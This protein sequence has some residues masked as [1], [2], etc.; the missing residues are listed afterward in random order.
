MSVLGTEAGDPWGW[1]GILGWLISSASL[2]S[3]SPWKHMR[4]FPESLSRTGRPIL[5]M[6]STNSMAWGPCLNKE[7]TSWVS[8]FLSP[9][10]SSVDKLW[11][12]AACPCCLDRRCL[13]TVSQKKSL[14]P[15]VTLVRYLVTAVRKV[16]QPG[17][18][19]GT[20]LSSQYLEGRGKWVWA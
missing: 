10:L 1:L 2:G 19:G 3:G 20:D 8:T 9:H 14:L 17:G 15:E 16:T 11:P 18:G 5:N 13:L 12:A 4:A 7:K 6:N